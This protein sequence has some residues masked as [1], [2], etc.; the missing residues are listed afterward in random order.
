M[1]Q[2]PTLKG[3]DD[4]FIEN[5]LEFKRIFDSAKPQDEPLPG[6]WD[7]KLDYFQKMIVIKAIRQDKVP[8]AIQNYVAEKIGK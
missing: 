1:S 4:Y 3:F 6:D 5:Q 8:F 7:E 2:L